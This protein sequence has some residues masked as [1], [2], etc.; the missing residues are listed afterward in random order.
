MKK[1]LT[2]IAAMMASTLSF[3][4]W[5][6]PDYPTAQP[7]TVDTECYLLNIDADGFLV[8]ANDWGTRA[9]YSS[10]SGALVIVKQFSS[11]DVAWDGES[12]FITNYVTS[13][14][15]ADTYASLY[16][17]DSGNTWVDAT[18]SATADNQGFTFADLGD[19]V[20]KIGFASVNKDELSG[21]GALYGAYLGGIPEENDTRLWICYPGSS[22]YDESTYQVRWI[23]VTPDDYTTYVAEEERYEAAVAL[24]EAITTAQEENDGIDISEVLTVYNNTSSTTEELTAAVETLTDLV[25]AFQTANVSATTPADY[26]VYITNPAYDDGDNDG[27]SGSTPSVS[28]GVAELYSWS[29]NTFDYYQTVDHDL[30]A[31]IYRVG[32]TGYYRSGT[33]DLDYTHY[34]S[35]DADSYRYVTLYATVGENTTTALLPLQNS[36]ASE[37]ALGGSTVTN[38][39][40]LYVPNSMEAANYY[41]E[42]GQYE[43]T[44]LLVSL[45]EGDAI[46]IGLKK[47]ESFTDNWAIWDN[48]TLSYLGAGSDAYKLLAEQVL[49]QYTD[50]EA[51]VA[52]GTV[53][54]YQKSVYETYLAAKTALSEATDADA[55]NE[56]ITAFEEAVAAMETS[57]AA[58]DALNTQFQT[59][60]DWFYTQGADTE[61]TDALGEY[62]DTVA[63]YLN[64]G[65]LTAEEAET[66]TTKLTELLY[67][68]MA[69]GMSDGDDCTSLL[70]NA[71][72]SESGGWTSAVGPTWPTDGVAV[73]EAINMVFDVYQELEGLQNGLYEFSTYALYR[74]CDISS[75]TGQEDYKAYVYIN[76]YKKKMNHI[77]DGASSTQVYSDDDQPASGY[78]PSSA[79]GAN[80]HFQAG[81]YAITVYGLVTDG[82]MRIGYLNN[83]RYADGSRAWWG[84]ATLTFRAKNEDAL[85]EATDLTLT[86]ATDMLKYYCG[87]PELN[88]LSDAI[89]DAEDATG[90]DIYDALVA[91]KAAMAA[92]DTCQTTYAS[93]SNAY[94]QLTATLEDATDADDETIAQAEAALA[95]AEAVLNDQ[96]YS[97]EEA[98]TLLETLNALNV[99]LKLG[100]STASLE[101]PEDV[102]SFI[103]NNTFDPDRG[104]KDSQYIEGWTTSAMNGYKGYSTSY[105]RA[106]I[107][108]YQDLT[109]LPEGTYKY[110]CH[111]FYRAGYYNEEENY[112]AI[113]TETHLATV[114][115]QTTDEYYST[116]MLNLTEGGTTSLP[117]G[118][119]DSQYKYDT[120]STGLYVP[121]NQLGSGFY[122][123]QG[124]YANEV[125]FYVGE[126]GKARIGVVKT[127]IISN[128]Y[129]VIGLQ[130]LYYYGSGDNT[131]VV[132]P[133][134]SIET[135]ATAT[136][137]AIYNLSGMRLGTT[138]RGVNIIKMSDGTARKVII[139]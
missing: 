63:D 46:T 37:T 76:S 7:L 126:D 123:A 1:I 2:L 99:S 23:F 82:T 133:V 92:V 53:E 79:T 119:D 100:D 108:L 51:A 60:Q 107:D 52:A 125:P 22:T 17:D 73:G 101:D 136:P 9:S 138:Q 127:E 33:N 97:N 88:A 112:M 129:S 70:A 55:V 118:W 117:D 38:E 54:F 19:N 16:I 39:A 59:A 43:P 44:T 94:D 13:G 36:G 102:S 69:S 93:L 104:D 50:Y 65:E 103:V 78:V 58:Y 68:A 84:P 115:V 67:D 132:T 18:T 120:T 90:E 47:T 15:L 12:Y 24:G 83:L 135:A 62:L 122:C 14:W 106:A 130:E 105:N 8:G 134:E 96:S 45:S 48:W 71:D 66:A 40:G 128:D 87:T 116:L 110:I 6:K 26:S 91:L 5:T 3:A 86:E 41:F 30:P 21:E 89:G 27:W 72:F 10:T 137:V 139:K 35:D 114:Y 124:Y 111:G 4:Q 34:T 121:N 113:G 56:A 61:E 80:A 81:S 98:T 75:V 74:P 57:V 25:V 32:V 49:A 11:D 28:Y 131:A 109:G 64:D 20:Y 85:R 42:A 29:A 31:G 77:L 95:E